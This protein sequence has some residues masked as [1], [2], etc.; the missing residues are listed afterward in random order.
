MTDPEPETSSDGR[1]DAG[2]RRSA[3]DPALGK[4]DREFFEAT[5]YPHLGAD[6]G[7]V[8]IGPRH[9]VDFGVLDVGGLAVVTAADPL[10]VLPELGL[11]RAGRL[12]IDIVLA[13][14]AVSGI[15]PTHATVSLA[16]PPAMADETA[17]AIWAAMSDHA[18]EL[19]V[20]VA[21][22]HVGRYPGVDSSW[23][24]GATALGVG[25]RE[26]L[27]RPDGARPGDAIVISTGPAAEVAGL[28]ATLFP[29][30]LGLPS[31]TL[32]TARERVD[33][34]EAVRDA[35]TAAAAGD[36]TAM[37]DATEGGIQGGLVEMARGAG[38]RFDVE[39]AAVPVRAGV[40][41]V[42]EAVG[43]DPWRATS[44]GTLLI[45]VDPSDAERVVSA[46]RDRGTL[47]AV[48]GA[49]SEGEGVYVDGERVERPSVD[50]SWAAFAEL[51]DR[52]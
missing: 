49:A 19:G 38:V 46:L 12:A 16:L 1:T 21:A 45:A 26:D 23:V 33:D 32:A 13:D 50:P 29:D 52:S 8:A 14:V 22:A 47:A 51:A 5:I 11:D 28:F 42:C 3:T 34:I 37:H 30:R 31:S 44:C 25:D 24:G 9:G 6:R 35:V 41:A 48:V 7:D 20:S 40:E 27:V 43:V 10:S 39:R 18:R 2:R 36:V 4:V 17:A 15:A